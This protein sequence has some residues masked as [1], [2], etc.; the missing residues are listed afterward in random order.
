[1]GHSAGTGLRQQRAGQSVANNP[2]VMGA[3]RGAEEGSAERGAG[4]RLRDATVEPINGASFLCRSHAR[5]WGQIPVKSP[6]PLFRPTT[7][8]ELGLFGD[9]TPGGAQAAD[10]TSL[11]YSDD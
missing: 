8:P 2:F 4:A 3:R 10:A 6:G 7:R 5:L 1:M 11:A 9:L